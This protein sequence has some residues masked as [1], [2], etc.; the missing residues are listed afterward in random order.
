M[1]GSPGSDV[2]RH[3]ADSG[4]AGGQPVDVVVVRGEHEC[5]TACDA[6]RDDVRVEEVFGAG[7]GG[8]EDRSDLLG[9]RQVG[10]HDRDGSRVTGAAV[11][12]GQRRFD[13]ARPGDTATHL[14]ADDRRDD[15]GVDRRLY[16]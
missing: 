14:G 11:V 1:V 9:E 2:A 15:P 10:R 7:V 13:G 6:C 8:V 12:T 4:H 3:D 5:R 16:T